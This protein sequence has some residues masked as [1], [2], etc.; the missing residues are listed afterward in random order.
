[1]HGI[2]ARLKGALDREE[3]RVAFQ[4]KVS[5]VSGDLIGVEALARWTDRDL[6]MVNPDVFIPA[7]EKS[8]CIRQ[9]TLFVLRRSL[10]VVASLR[11]VH[12]AAT[13]AVNVSPTLLHD[14]HFA[15]EVGRLLEETGVSPDALVAEI[16]ETAVLTDDQ[17]VKDTL[18]RLRALGVG[19]SIDDFGTGH[20]SLLA[21]LRMPFS[22]LKIDRAF[23]MS[24]DADLEAWKIVRATLRLARELRLDVVAEGIETDPVAQR[25][26]EGGCEVGQ[27]FRF[28]A[29]IPGAMLLS[30]V[31][32][33]GHW[34]TCR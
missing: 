4:P 7:A 13:V 26:R 28:G 27:G 22:E 31:R 8:G 33:G 5:L 12:P 3:L 17:V 14:P 32:S 18:R 2:T 24:C 29:A 11:L 10:Q 19:C 15:D 30:N 34:T 9:L 25:L 21:L 23:I 16:T 1:M 20:A 6:G